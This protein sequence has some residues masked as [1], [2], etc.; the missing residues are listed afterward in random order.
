MSAI[1]KWKKKKRREPD[2][3]RQISELRYELIFIDEI[4]DRDSI[5]FFLSYYIGWDKKHWEWEKSKI[6]MHDPILF[7]STF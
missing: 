3:A 5:V 6:I 7:S 2:K 4:N 1:I